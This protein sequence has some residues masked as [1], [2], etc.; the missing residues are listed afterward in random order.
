MYQLS[1]WC[2]LDPT[3]LSCPAYAS[4]IWHV[5]VTLYQLFSWC[6]TSQM[7]TV[8]AV[9]LVQDIS[10]CISCLAEQ[11][12]SGIYQESSWHKL[13]PLCIK[14]QLSCRRGKG[15]HVQCIILLH[16]CWWIIKLLY[17]LWCHQL[18]ENFFNVLM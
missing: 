4:L 16:S 7:Q 5:S 3:C 14:P 8:L 12:R 10:Q 2:K 15:H 1:S 17:L 18:R 13:D 6:N 11:V 9:W